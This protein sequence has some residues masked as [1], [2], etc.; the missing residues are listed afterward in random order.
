MEDVP[1]SLSGKKVIGVQVIPLEHALDHYKNSWVGGVYYR[2]L[3]CERNDEFR[4]KIK[5]IVKKTDG[6]KY[7]LW[8]GDW[9]RALFDVELG[10][11]QLTSRFWCSALVAY[12]YVELGF[13]D[14]TLEWSMIAPRQFSYYENKRLS[15]KNSEINAERHII[16]I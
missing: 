12:L 7:D 14:K 4:E 10:D 3:T 11:R 9:L 16:D 15:Y 6:I 5:T 8:I 1:D 2:K 13:L